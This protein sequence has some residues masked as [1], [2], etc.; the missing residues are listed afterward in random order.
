MPKAGLD[1]MGPDELNRPKERKRAV[2]DAFSS[3]CP[4]FDGRVFVGASSTEDRSRS[5]CE[6]QM[7]PREDC[8]PS[9][10]AIVRLGY[11][12]PYR[13]PELL[14]FFRARMLSGVE[15]VDESSYARTVCLHG[16]NGKT[17]QGWLRVQDDP[18]RNELVVTM[19]ESLV[20][21]APQVIARVRRLFDCDC[22]PQTIAGRL[23]SLDNIVPGAVREGTR[24]PGCFE[25]FETACRAVLGQQI[26]VSAANK[27]AARIVKRF[28][29]PVETGIDGLTHAFP[30]PAD[31]LALDSIENVFG[32]LG[33]IRARS[34]VIAQ[35]ARM[36]D[37]GQLDLS[38]GAVPEEQIE[39][40]L[41]IKGVGPWTANYIAM[42]VLSHPDAF[43]E[44]D[45]G[46]AHALPNMTPRQR[47]AEAEAWRPWRSYAVIS[48]WNSLVD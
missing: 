12:P 5:A 42:R 4:R 27:L 26:S 47:L 30:A 18:K 40:L 44:K 17:V 21:C 28:G 2:F 37:S 14:S 23:A 48:L 43:L 6:G 3:S 36:L 29:T 11:R 24:L 35:I 39:T 13:F 31:V 45:A 46:V 8:A 10:T 16:P 20:P 19:S 22:D 41:S 33:V 32:E 38:M 7:A 1:T 34:K 15:V 9:G 25:P